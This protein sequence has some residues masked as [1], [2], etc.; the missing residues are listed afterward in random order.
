MSIRNKIFEV[1]AALLVS[2]FPALADGISN[3]GGSGAGLTLTVNSTA[4]SGAT[5]GQALYSDGTKLQ[6][7]GILIGSG[8]NIY[9]GSAVGSTVTVNGTSNGSPSA[10]YVF[11]D[12]IGNKVSIG[13]AVNP[14]ASLTIYGGTQGAQTVAPP[15]TAHLHIVG[16]DGTFTVMLVDDFSS[17]AANGNNLQFRRAD[18]TLASKTALQANDVIANIG[19]LGFDG[20]AYSGGQASIRFIAQ[21]NWVNG[22]DHATF[23]DFRT[24][25]AG[26]VTLGVAAKLFGSGGFS[27]GPTPVDPGAGGIYA[28]GQIAAPNITATSAGVTGTVCWTTGTGA[29][30]IDTTTTCL[31]SLEELKDK[32]GPII[33][34]LDIV[35]RLDP[36]WFSW[37]EGTTQR[38]GDTQVQPGFGAHQVASVDPRLA[39]YDKDGNLRGVRYQ[40]MTAV[41][42]AALKEAEFRIAELE[43]KAIWSE[44]PP[45]TCCMPSF[46]PLH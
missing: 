20:T 34:A 44:S 41:L 1:V 37:R 18:G 25:P 8:G 38:A 43:R 22:S 15:N 31:L 13:Q 16:P 19:A 17:G 3:P 4:V 26:S 21:D 32:R 28:A 42:A 45:L 7:S 36:F 6:A 24:T 23:I 14:D 10:A 33:G 9:G 29:F 30:T 39:A 11:I 35:K 46:A 5:A 27:I 2:A 12:T 40:E